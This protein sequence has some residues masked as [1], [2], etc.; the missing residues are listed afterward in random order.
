MRHLVVVDNDGKGR[1][2]FSCSAEGRNSDDFAIIQILGRDG[3]PKIEL[4]VNSDSSCIRL[5]SSSN[6]PGVSLA[7]GA[8]ANGLNIGDAEGRPIIEMGKEFGSDEFVDTAG[9]YVREIDSTGEITA[10]A[11]LTPKQ[12]N[13]GG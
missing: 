9:V 10:E 2:T 4:Q 13:G 3:L 1:I 12:S 5:K 7:A 8:M 6:R 11:S